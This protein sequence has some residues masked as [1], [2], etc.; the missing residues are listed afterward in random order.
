M[1]GRVQEDFESVRLKVADC[2]ELM[3]GAERKTATAAGDPILHR[4]V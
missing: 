2:L 1:T 4:E 3:V